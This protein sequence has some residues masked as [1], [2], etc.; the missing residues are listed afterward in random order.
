MQ[1]SFQL[2]ISNIQ[3]ILECF[4]IFP[5]K[6]ADYSFFAILKLERMKGNRMRIIY[7]YNF[8]QIKIIYNKYEYT[9]F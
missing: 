8:E 6:W 5:E 7:K 1:L 2:K 3:Y 9:Q 4:L